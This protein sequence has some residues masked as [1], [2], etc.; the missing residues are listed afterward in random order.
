MQGR[1][2]LANLIRWPGAGWALTDRRHTRFTRRQR[3]AALEADRAA[4]VADEELRLLAGV[5]GLD[6]WTLRAVQRPG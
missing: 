6:L 3:Y 2:T 5:L 1:D 4:N